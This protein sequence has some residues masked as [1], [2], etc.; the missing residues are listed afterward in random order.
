MVDRAAISS[1]P[2]LDGL[3]RAALDA[4]TFMQS[5]LGSSDLPVLLGRGAVMNEP[6]LAS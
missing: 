2:R 1:H 6:R 4:P 3:R 5:I